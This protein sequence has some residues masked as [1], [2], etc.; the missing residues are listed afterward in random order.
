MAVLFQVVGTILI[1]IAVIFFI[2]KNDRSVT[3]ASKA[4]MFL[5]GFQIVLCGWFF[6]LC[7]SD[8]LDVGVNFSPVR[9]ILNVIY[10]IAF[11]AIS[12]YTL[13]NKYKRD[14]KYLKTVIGAFILLFGVQCFVFPYETEQEFLRIF[15]ALEGAVVYGLLIAILIKLDDE[16]FCQKSLFAATVLELA[17]AVENV[18]VPFATITEDFQTIDIPLNYAALFMRPVL[19]ASLALTY[20]VWLDRKK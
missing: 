2:R 19:M 13:F 17:V 3:G 15:E 16:K 18:I 12:I 14:D 4:Q 9:F 7:L 6:A 8:V 11:S 1:I 5:A 20:R 10:G